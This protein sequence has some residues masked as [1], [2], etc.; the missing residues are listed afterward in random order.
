M[1]RRLRG[2]RR[3]WGRSE[4]EGV[5]LSCRYVCR[6]CCVRCCCECLFIR[7]G[8][9]ALPERGLPSVLLHRSLFSS[10]WSA[11]QQHVLLHALL[12]D[13]LLNGFS[14]VLVW[15]CVWCF[16]SLV[17]ALVEEHVLHLVLGMHY[18]Q[19]QRGSGMRDVHLVP[20]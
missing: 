14:L 11:Q 5:L 8:T 10:L 20:V 18:D 3:G 13:A 16:A 19:K 15:C 2:L 9:A 17:H 4:C 1:C 6:V 7:S 12:T